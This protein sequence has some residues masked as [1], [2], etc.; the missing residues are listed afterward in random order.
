VNEIFECMV[1]G[2]LNGVGHGENVR[3]VMMLLEEMFRLVEVDKFK[4]MF[5]ATTNSFMRVSQSMTIFNVGIHVVDVMTERWGFMN[6][7]LPGLAC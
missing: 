7:D 2:S 1:L 3:I 6:S 4:S 5:F